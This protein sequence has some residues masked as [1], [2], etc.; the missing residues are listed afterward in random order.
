MDFLQKVHVT[1]RGISNSTYRRFPHWLAPE[2]TLFGWAAK[3]PSGS[4]RTARSLRQTNDFT[5][6]RGP[7]YA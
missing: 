5:A 1:D 7:G 4:R 2:K 3:G 6:A